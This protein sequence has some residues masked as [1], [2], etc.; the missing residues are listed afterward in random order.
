M[1]EIKGRGLRN[2]VAILFGL[3]VFLTALPAFGAEYFVNK[4]GND[5]NNGLTRDRAFLTIQKGLD[6]LKAGDT[7]TVG[8]GEYFE[9]VK[10]AN[11]GGPDADTVI[12]AEI[13]GTAVL[14]G[15]V[16]A[17][18]FKKVKGYRF[19]Y[20]AKFDPEPKAVLEHNKLHT[21][22]SKANI[23]ELEFDPGAFYY[24]AD[25]KRLY[26]SNPDLSSA[27]ECRYALAV[28]GESGIELDSPRRVVIDGLALAGFHPQDGISLT[29]PVSCTIRNCVCFMNVKGIQLSPIGGSNGA[30]CGSGNLIEN[31]VCYG[32]RFS[33]ISRYR[34]NNDVIRNCYMYENRHHKSF[35]QGQHLLGAEVRLFRQA[36]YRGKTGKLRGAGVHQER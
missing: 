29:A 31:C 36:D 30:N 11:L 35:D 13:P 7:L 22:L 21:L 19:V 20:A 16:P 33:G 6:A 17:P 1:G 15:D 8:P 28:G 9:N 23:A 25:C 12:R 4:Q 2:V 26:I 10:R 24:D 34:A 14:R 32:N 18:Q 3:G 27:D 5:A